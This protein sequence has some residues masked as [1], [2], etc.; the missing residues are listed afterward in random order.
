MSQR[1]KPRSLELP[2]WPEIGN[3]VGSGQDNRVFQLVGHAEKPHLRVPVGMVLKINHQTPHI[4]FAR[5]PDEREAAWRGLK[6]K[7]NK[8]ELLKL[9]LGDFVPDTAFVLGKVHE[10][11][12]ERYAEYTVQQEVPRISLSNLTQEQQENPIL[13]SQITELMSRLQYMY[14][15]LGEA[16]ARS[17]HSASLDG[18][19]NLGG[20]STLVRS[21]GLDYR[22]T[23]DDAKSIIN[24]NSSPNLLIDPATMQLYCIDFGQGQWT[25]SMDKTKTMVE[26]IVDEDRQAGIGRLAVQ[27]NSN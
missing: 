16:N 15:V 13:I 22:F 8:Y 4:N 20:V 23:T 5:H 11:H 1:S 27:A 25:D 10:G 21:E 17:D 7:K 24:E 14:D 12:S 18:A 2:F 3:I 9:F 6:Y 19:L 26:R